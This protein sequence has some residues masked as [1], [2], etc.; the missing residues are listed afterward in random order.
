MSA[1][2]QTRTFSCQGV[3]AR[4]AAHRGAGCFLSTGKYCSGIAG[5]CHEVQRCHARRL[6]LSRRRAGSTVRS[7]RSDCTTKTLK[8]CF[9]CVLRLKMAPKPGRRRAWDTASLQL[10]CSRGCASA[11][12]CPPASQG[13]D[14]AG[15][16]TLMHMLKDERLVTLQ[17]T[18]M[19][20]SEV[21]SAATAAW[22]PWGAQPVATRAYVVTAICKDI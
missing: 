20:T 9:W 13:L 8:S 7:M 14:N 1:W 12:R 6:P 21:C 3:R 18:Q 10:C 19:P 17:P 4:G 16:T 5:A 11:D 22:L 15:K 2:V